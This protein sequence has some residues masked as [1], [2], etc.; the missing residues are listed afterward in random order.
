MSLIRNAFKRLHYPVDIIAQW[1]V[2][3]VRVFMR[4]TEHQSG[5]RAEWVNKQRERK[6][7][8]V[9]ACALANKLARIAWAITTQHT[10]FEKLY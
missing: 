4:R 10:V 6:H 1:L 9:V 3:C 7:A 8:N 2:L 5:K